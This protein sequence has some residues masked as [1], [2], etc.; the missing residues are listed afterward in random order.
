MYYLRIIKREF[1][2]PPQDTVAQQSDL[3]LVILVVGVEEEL[4][5]ILIP[6]LI[7]VDR[8][9]RQV[10]FLPTEYH[11]FIRFIPLGDS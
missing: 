5:H 1:G 8:A 11:D 6:I 9:E 10:K 3:D 7:T 2:I 4:F